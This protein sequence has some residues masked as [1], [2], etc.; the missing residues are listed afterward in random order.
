MPLYILIKDDAFVMREKEKEK[1][2]S[3]IIFLL[4]GSNLASQTRISRYTNDEPFVCDKALLERIVES[5]AQAFIAQ[6][7]NS[8]NLSIINKEILSITLNGYEVDFLPKPQKINE[9]KVTVAFAA[10]DSIYLKKVTETIDSNNKK[11]IKF[12]SLPL[13]LVSYIFNK[14]KAQ[15]FILVSVY[16]F[17]VDISVRKGKGFFETITVPIG[18]SEVIKHIA[19]GLSISNKDALNNFVQYIESKLDL[20]LVTTFEESLQSFYISLDNEIKKGF[21]QLSRGTLLPS[22]IYLEVPTVFKKVYEHAFRDNTYHSVSFSETGFE[23][24]TI[25][26]IIIS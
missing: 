21:T 24:E 3:E 14:T 12:R 23:V 9:L 2:N 11:S 1:K 5:S 7:P 26:S 16:E 4:S 8:K 20:A 18:T 6:T 19:N 13:A 17:S 15:D 22:K 10:L 25:D